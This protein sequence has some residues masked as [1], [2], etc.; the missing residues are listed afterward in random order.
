MAGATECPAREVGSASR[1]GPATR[2]RPGGPG[3]GCPSPSRSLPASR[4]LAGARVEVRGRA[5]HGTRART[6]ISRPRAGDGESE[7]NQGVTAPLAEG[8]DDAEVGNQVNQLISHCPAQPVQNP[9]H[10]LSCC[11]GKASNINAEGRDAGRSAEPCTPAQQPQG[12]LGE[13]PAEADAC[14]PHVPPMAP[15]AGAL[16]AG[17]RGGAAL[18]APAARPGGVPET[19]R[20]R[21]P[22]QASAPFRSSGRT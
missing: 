3:T 1:A 16:W 10:W 2:G 21:F 8:S 5:R 18:R 15:P 6:A 13:P 4:R 9:A 7:E 22:G 17:A 14:R 11:C 19:R 20:P 12:A